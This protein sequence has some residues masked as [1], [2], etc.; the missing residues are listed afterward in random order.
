M[1][2][3]AAERLVKVLGPMLDSS[4]GRVGLQ[5]LINEIARL[6]PDLIRRANAAIELRAVRRHP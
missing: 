4:D 6:H 5:T 3:E 1:T 2:R